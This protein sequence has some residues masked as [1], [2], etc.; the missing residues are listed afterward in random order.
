MAD[1]ILVWHVWFASIDL[2]RLTRRLGNTVPSTIPTGW[3]LARILSHS[4]EARLLV[5]VGTRKLKYLSCARQAENCK[6]ENS[7]D[8][9]KLF[10][11]GFWQTLSAYEVLLSLLLFGDDVP[12]APRCRGHLGGFS[13][14]HSWLGLLS[15]FATRVDGW[16]HRDQGQKSQVSNWPQQ[17]WKPSITRSGR[18]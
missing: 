8:D 12:P 15:A 6:S 13:S 5:A 2:N 3:D 14:Q 10:S 11:V 4:L 16:P 17:G 18:D 7:D 1:G 9:V